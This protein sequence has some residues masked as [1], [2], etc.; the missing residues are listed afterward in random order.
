MAPIIPEGNQ[1]PKR[2]GYDTR[3]NEAISLTFKPDK[4]LKAFEIVTAATSAV[5]VVAQDR[6][7]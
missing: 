6:S 2:K 7:V 3:N 4:N 5:V 1:L